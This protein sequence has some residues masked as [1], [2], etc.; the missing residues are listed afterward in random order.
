MKNEIQL[1]PAQ[2]KLWA[3]IGTMAGT[4]FM[5]ILYWACINYGHV[6]TLV[7]YV[8]AGIAGAALVIFGIWQGVYA[9]IDKYFED[10]EEE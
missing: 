8:L 4:I 9:I 10:K 7:V 2:K 1:T 5:Y 6:L 3:S